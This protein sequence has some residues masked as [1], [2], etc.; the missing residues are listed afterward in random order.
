MEPAR[1][2][3][4]PHGPP[5]LSARTASTCNRGLLGAFFTLAGLVLAACV[6]FGTPMHAV[7]REVPTVEECK[8]SAQA[9][10]HECLRKCIEIQCTGIKINCR[11]EEIQKKCNERNSNSPG[12]TMGYV[13]R[14]SDKPTSCDHP[15]T[16]V[17][18]CEEPASRECRAKAMVHELAHSCG[19]QHGQGFGVPGDNGFLPCE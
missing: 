8:A 4:R 1:S 2:G 10:T 3:G 18:W 17:N 9:I 13:I 15:S 19:W 6:H 5:D 7:C 11:S 12:S 16:E 14:F